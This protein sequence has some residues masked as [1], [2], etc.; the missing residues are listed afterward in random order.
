[1]DKWSKAFE[2]MTSLKE[3]N[4][5]GMRDDIEDVDEKTFDEKTSTVEYSLD[6]RQRIYWTDGTFPDATMKE[7]D[8]K[9]LEEATHHTKVGNYEK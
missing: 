6:E 5:V 4:C 1:V 8:V 7:E 9:K 2:K 3:L